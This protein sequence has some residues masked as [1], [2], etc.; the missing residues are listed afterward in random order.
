MSLSNSCEISVKVHAI[1]YMQHAIKSH[2]YYPCRLCRSAWVGFL[3]Q[4]VCLSVCPNDP[5]V[6]KLGIEN[7]LGIP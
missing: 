7:D 5:K 3:S 2:N 1:N 4:C 6:F